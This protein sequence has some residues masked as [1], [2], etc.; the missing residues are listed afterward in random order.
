M[1][2]EDEV[3]TFNLSDFGRSIGNNGDGTD[4]AWGAHHFVLG[5]AVTGGLYGKLPDLTL[6]GVDDISSKGR[7]IPST[8]MSQYLGTIVKWFGADEAMLNG[9]F[10]ERGNFTEK[11]LGFMG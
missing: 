2:M 7:L 9:L 11:D 1:G 4:H 6:G 8:S 10:T 3:T 5:G